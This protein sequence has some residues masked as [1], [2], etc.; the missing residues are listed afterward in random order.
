MNAIRRERYGQD[1]LFKD[2]LVAPLWVWIAL[3]FEYASAMRS[4]PV[5]VN[6][7]TAPQNIIGV[8]TVVVGQPHLW[9]VPTDAVF[10]CR[11]AN[12]HFL[13]MFAVQFF[14]ALL[15]RHAFRRM[16]HDKR[17]VPAFVKRFL[18]VI[19]DVGVEVVEA[20]FPGIVFLKQR[21]G[22]VFANRPKVEL[23][24]FY[25]PDNAAIEQ[26]MST[27]IMWTGVFFAYVH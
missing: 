9:L 4:A 8:A 11:I 13:R 26:Q 10:R 23:G 16:R 14:L 22:A 1:F 17:A 3:V 12:A 21:I 24:V 27:C 25:I 19:D 6:A 7:A 18:L 15:N 2:G 5:F 20:S